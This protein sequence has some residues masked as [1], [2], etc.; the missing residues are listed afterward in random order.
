MNERDKLISEKKESLEKRREV[1]VGELGNLPKPKTNLKLSLG[2]KGE[3]YFLRTVSDPKDLVPVYSRLLAIK[4]YTEQ[5]VKDLGVEDF[6]MEISGYLYEDWISDLKNL[7]TLL[8][9]KEK[10][11][12]IE[13]GLKE[14]EKFYS[15]GKKEE[16]A[17][18]NLFSGL[19]NL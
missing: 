18:N 17:F 7:S 10:I 5:A 12:K 14:L 2:C 4:S 1:L 6:P 8:T 9:L 11:Q 16:E 19:S 3:E 13:K 15:D